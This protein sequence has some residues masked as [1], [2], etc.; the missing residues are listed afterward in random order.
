MNDLTQRTG[1]CLI[2]WHPTLIKLYLLLSATDIKV[3]LSLN[4]KHLHLLYIFTDA[5]T[6]DRPLTN[7]ADSR[8]TREVRYGREIFIKTHV[9]LSSFYREK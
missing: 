8:D 7:I 5:S 1:G 6:I 9:A 3:L 2:D 4:K